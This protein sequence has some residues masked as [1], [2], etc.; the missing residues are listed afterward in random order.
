M[1]CDCAT[2]STLTCRNEAR[3]ALVRA[4]EVNGLDYLEVSDD[5]LEL[6]V[7]FLGPAPEGLGIEHIEICGG[8]R[9]RDIA[10]VDLRLCPQTDPERDNCIIVTVDRPGDFSTYCLCLVNLPEDAPFDPRYRCLEFSFKAACPSDLDCK[11]ERTCPEEVAPA[12]EIDYLAKD[13]ASF[14]RLILDRLAVL[15]P[16][17]TERHVPD[18]GITLVELLA[19][20]GDYLSY[21][22]DAVATEAYLD[23]ARK[24]VSV[25]RHAR[26]VDYHLH[27]GCNARTWVAVET[28]QD[29]ALAAPDLAFLTSFE[30]APDTSA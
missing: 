26:L 14:R 2:D 7:Y 28:S 20:V 8:V 15:M 1:S 21:H 11:Q 30:G 19:Y 17:W 10:V 12:P 5:Q 29:I 25:R 6:T 27:E 18:V 13:Y 3:R 16:H 24:R 23:T 22:Q 9:E 4:A